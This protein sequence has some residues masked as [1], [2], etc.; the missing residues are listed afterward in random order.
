MKMA[1]IRQTPKKVSDLQS[2]AP[3]AVYAD[4]AAA[5]ANV[6]PGQCPFLVVEVKL[7]CRF[8]C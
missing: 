4:A 8:S 7:S 6:S 1:A 3:R 2:A 5:D